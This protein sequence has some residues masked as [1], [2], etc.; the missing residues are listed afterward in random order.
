M[1]N[2]GDEVICVDD[3]PHVKQMFAGVTFSASLV[4]GKQYTIREFIPGNLSFVHH[5]PHVLLNEIVG[6]IADGDNREYCFKASRFRKAVKTDIGV[7]EKFKQPISILED[8]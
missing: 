2:P 3:R 7:F 5:E 4:K 8:A 6:S 1:F